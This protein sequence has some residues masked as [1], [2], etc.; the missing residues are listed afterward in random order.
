M[1]L[2][3][4]VRSLLAQDALSARQWVADARRAGV[5]WSKVPQPE[6]L[7]P[8]AMVVAAGVV[9]MMAG[10]AGE[11]PPP[12]TCNV[13]A[14]PRPILMVRAAETMPRLRA[15]CEREGP[16]PLRRR[17]VLAPPEFLTVA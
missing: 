1:D 2:R 16:E 5:S 15:L 4:L 6:G 12:W 13:E 17:G 11:P 3:D 8:E 10:R 9:E 14:S 7:S